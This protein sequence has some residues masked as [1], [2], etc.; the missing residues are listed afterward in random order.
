MVLKIQKQ[1]R[2]NNSRILITSSGVKAVLLINLPDKAKP[3]SMGPD[4]YNT[5]TVYISIHIC[6][7]KKKKRDRSINWVFVFAPQDEKS[8]Q[9]KKQILLKKGNWITPTILHNC[10]WFNWF[11]FPKFTTMRFSTL[12]SCFS[13]LK[14][15]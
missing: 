8:H 14:L 4:K 11:D 6:Q 13:F 9:N 3:I 12:F 5:R 7:T 15:S 1:K 10:V 2:Q